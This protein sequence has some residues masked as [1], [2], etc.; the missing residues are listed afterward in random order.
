MARFYKNDG[1]GVY[2]YVD[3]MKLATKLDFNKLLN[4]L[5][6]ST[7]VDIITYSFDKLDF[8]KMLLNQGKSVRLIL[9]SK[10]RTFKRAYGDLVGL[11]DNL[12]IYV[13]D[14]IH[15]KWIL[16]DSQF[17]YTGS[18][19]LEDSDSF[20]NISIFNDSK[21]Y[22]YYESV[23]NNIL[24]GITPYN[25]KPINNT[26]IPNSPTASC[27]VPY[28]K[29]HSI[30]VQN[31]DIKF[32]ANGM[33]NWNQKFNGYHNR[34]ILITTFSIPKFDYANEI[35]NKI[36]RQGNRLHIVANNIAKNK[37]EKLKENNPSLTYSISPNI[38]AK[39]VLVDGK[40]KIVW[41]SSQN[42]GSSTWTEDTVNIK[43]EET[44][45]YFYK[46]ALQELII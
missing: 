26:L 1:G 6:N 20:E 13:N 12:A 41:S 5:S 28:E 34:D 45:Y 30:N 32:S 36:L 44:P 46:K 10:S 38:H 23:F 3:S 21:I 27:Y 31:L 4:Q 18:Q 11:S 42:F 35:V 29:T 33:V 9:N 37:L 15:S 8:I 43:G 7:K 14:K 40:N 39:L 25:I 16:G 2:C 22:E 17:V 24:Q 19:N